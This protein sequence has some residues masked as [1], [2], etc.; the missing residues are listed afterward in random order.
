MTIVNH[1]DLAEI[2]LLGGAHDA[3]ADREWCL[4]EAA[5]YMAGEPW[6][7][8]PDCVSPV[9]AA[10]GRRWNDDLDDEG[11]QRLVALLPKMIGTR[12]TEAD[13]SIRAWMCTDWM[14]RSYLPAWLDLAGLTEQASTVRAFPP[15]TSAATVQMDVLDRVRQDADADAAGAAAGAAARV[16]AWAWVAAWNAAGPADADAA[17]AAA[18][19]AAALRP[20]VVGLQ[21]SAIDLFDRMCGVGR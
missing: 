15:L 7:D 20:T 9:I 5:A 11:R 14:V 8:H 16:A 19:A 3:N 13:E 17:G 21:V 18:G 6:S 10:F 12:T 1:L 2:H 4:L